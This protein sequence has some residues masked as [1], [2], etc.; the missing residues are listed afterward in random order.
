MLNIWE[1]Y[2]LT[3]FLKT[4][5]LFLLLFFGLYVVIDYATHAAT[6]YRNLGAFFWINVSKYYLAEF[7]HRLDVLLPF[8]LLTAT[9]RTLSNFNTHNELVAL[10]CSGVSLKRLTTPFIAVALICTGIVYANEEWFLPE[11]AQ[12]LQ[13]MSESRSSERHKKAKLSAVNSVLLEDHSILLFQDYHPDTKELFD[14]FWIRN[15]NDIYHIRQLSLSI[16]PVGHSVDHLVRNAKG[17]IVMSQSLD[18][19]SFPEMQI[20][21]EGL[22]SVFNAPEIQPLSTLIDNLPAES[23]LSNEKDAHT[24]A[25]LLR[26]LWMP[27]LCVLA[28]MIPAPFCWQYSR[29]IPLFLI[30]AVGIFGLIAF[31]LLTNATV[32]LGRRQVLPPFWIV[33]T[34][35]FLAFGYAAWL[36]TRM[37]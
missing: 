12:I 22:V 6:F 20:P 14:I 2:F 36:F 24:T 30:Y 34:P 18:T 1:R 10:M 13:Q 11:A 35:F 7:T 25:I 19:L 4:F 37:K 32:L 5:F 29:N 23:E 8:A 26:K 15:I 27:W 3:E 9:V 33:S 17:Q 31:Y 16:P 28:V 21:A